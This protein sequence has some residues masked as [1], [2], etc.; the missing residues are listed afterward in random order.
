LIARLEFF[1][2]HQLM[3]GFSRTTSRFA[4]AVIKGLDLS[5]MITSDRG[6]GSAFYRPAVLFSVLVYGY[7][8]GVFLSRQSEC[9]TYGGGLAI[10]K[11]CTLALFRAFVRTAPTT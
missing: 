1:H 6:S 2:R 11:G 10:F 9:G 4:V 7:A 3:N 8:T 5:A